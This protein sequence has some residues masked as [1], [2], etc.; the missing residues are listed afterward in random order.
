MGMMGMMWGQLGQRGD[1]RD[2][3]HNMR[4]RPQRLRS[5]QPWGTTWG[6]SGGY[7]DDMGTMGTT[8]G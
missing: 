5:P 8:Q 3:G 1:H 6:P 2:N 7:E 4:W